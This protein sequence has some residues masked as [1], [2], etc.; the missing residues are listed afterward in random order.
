MTEA[1][2]FLSRMDL[3]N[4]KFAGRHYNFFITLLR[5]PC[6]LVKTRTGVLRAI[7]ESRKGN[8]GLRPGTVPVG[9]VGQSPRLKIRAVGKLEKEKWCENSYEFRL[10]L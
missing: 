1:G 5:P 6:F 7:G 3:R 2:G 9:A 8:T 10:G 4:I